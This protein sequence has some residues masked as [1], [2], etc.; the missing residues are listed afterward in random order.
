[1]KK[2]KLKVKN[3]NTSYSIVIGRNVLSQISFQINNLCPNAQKIALVIDKNVPIKFKIKL[4]KYLKK[5]QI[6]SFEYTFLIFYKS[7]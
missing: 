2:T 7:C 6:Y 4:K 1:M 3:F 5:Y